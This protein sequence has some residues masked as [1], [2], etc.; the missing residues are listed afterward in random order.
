MKNQ[1][2][3][4]RETFG[5]F[6]SENLPYPYYILQGLLRHGCCNKTELPSIALE[7]AFTVKKMGPSAAEEPFNYDTV[8]ST[9]KGRGNKAWKEASWASA[10]QLLPL[11]SPGTQCCPR[12]PRN[13]TAVVPYV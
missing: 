13:G 6:K 2:S 11:G 10:V 4:I 12:R 8:W 5:G 1:T 9:V 3:I 7:E